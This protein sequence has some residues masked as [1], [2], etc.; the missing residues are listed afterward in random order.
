MNISSLNL[1]WVVQEICPDVVI[2]GYPCEFAKSATAENFAK[3]AEIFVI[4]GH[5]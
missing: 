3:F 4:F 2:L 5:V 1:R